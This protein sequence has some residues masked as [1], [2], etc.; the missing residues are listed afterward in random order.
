MAAGEKVREQRATSLLVSVMFHGLAVLGVAASSWWW[1]AS[2]L[3]TWETY[4]VSLVDVPLSLRPPPSPAPKPAAKPAQPPKTPT[5]AEPKKVPKVTKPA[6]TPKIAKPAPRQKTKP[7]AR[8]VQAPAEPP[9]APQASTSQEARSAVEALR[10]R[11]AKR[12]QVR[13]D[14]EATRQQAASARVAALR[15]QLAQEQSVDGSSGLQQVRLIAYQDRVRAKIIEAW[16]LPLSSEQTRDLQATAQFEVTR[17]GNVM[18]LELV[19]SSGNGLFDASLLRAIR[20]ASPLPA[21][22][23]DY[24]VDVLE[25]EMRFRAES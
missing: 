16:I 9:R 25:V 13:Q 3:D 17:N 23:D 14:A 5:V 24:P 7:P 18:Q 2:T 8:A 1:G 4:T 6:P 21:L 22:P 10:Q 20:R 19:K 11:Q 12:D 15:D